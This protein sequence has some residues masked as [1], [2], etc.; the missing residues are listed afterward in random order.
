MK[1]VRKPYQMYVLNLDAGRIF[2]LTI[3]LLL[4]LLLSF[5]AGY[6]I[7]KEK[8]KNDITKLAEKNKLIME[9]IVKNISN[10]SEDN[11]KYEFYDMLS[12]NNYKEENIN[13]SEEESTA[14]DD[15][16]FKKSP[17]E[18]IR[19]KVSSP[20]PIPVNEKK[21]APTIKKTSK[22]RKN[23]II[24]NM[25]FSKNSKDKRLTSKRPYTIQVASY[26][27]YKNALILYKLLKSEQYPSYILRIKI[28]GK[29]YYRVRVG[30]FASKTLSIKVLQMI[31]RLKGC[32][33]SYIT[34]K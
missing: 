10:N 29:I 23:K 8:T 4:L 20:T 31:K 22:V 25:V 3:I 2:W 14:E 13:S 1:K 26:S 15:I 30:P 11:D 5:I 33:G 34:T 32:E 9:K 18:N 7:G 19:K 24:N 27:T 21:T 17:E 12:N 28:R 6:I 16:I